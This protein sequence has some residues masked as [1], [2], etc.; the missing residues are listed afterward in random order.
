[1]I[2][3]LRNI[4]FSGFVLPVYSF[5]YSTDSAHSLPFE[6]AV[7]HIT[8]SAHLVIKTDPP[9]TKA[10]QVGTNIEASTVYSVVTGKGSYVELSPLKG[11]NHTLHAPL[12]RMG[13]KTALEFRSNQHLFIFQ[14]TALLCHPQISLKIQ[15]SECVFELHGKGTW[16][17]EKT[18]IGFKLVIL[19]GQL[20]IGENDSPPLPPGSLSLISGKEGQK[21]QPIDIELPLL[22]G[23]SRL[24]NQF[25]GF[26][27][28][29]AKISSAALV[30][31]M[32]VTTKYDALI[33]NVAADRKLQIWS[34]GE[35][36]K[37]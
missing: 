4:L 29:K 13:N 3:R 36:E 32:K 11:S 16:M 5:L 17:L 31:S 28:S 27:P 35:N 22:L 12:I 37:K 34:I 20:S 1:L 2:L 23:T 30:Q 33:G 8:G 10:L 14:G 25:P 18:P 19:E 26:L 7:S 9:L 15:S 24:L 21:S 6:F